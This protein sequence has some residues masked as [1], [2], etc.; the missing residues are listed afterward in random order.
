M[1]NNLIFTNLTHQ[2]IRMPLRIKLGDNQEAITC[3]HALRLLPQK[4]LT[5][6][7]TWKNKEVIVKIFFAPLKAKQHIKREIDGYALIHNTTDVLAPKILKKY[8]I[9]EQN[10]NAEILIIEKITAK[11]NVISTEISPIIDIASKLHKAGILLNDMHANNFIQAENGTYVIDPADISVKQTPL[12]IKNILANIAALA[13]QTHNHNLDYAMSIF[14]KYAK[15]CDINFSPRKRKVFIKIY[16]KLFLKR[17]KSLLKKVLRNSSKYIYEKTSKHL[18]ICD[19]E[20]YTQEMQNLVKHTN[21]AFL[22]KNLIKQ[23]GKCTLAKIKIS[24]Q[25]LIIKRYNLKHAFSILKNQFKFSRAKN[26][27]LN[28]HRLWLYDIPTPKPIAMLEKSTWFFKKETF[29][30]C[31]YIDGDKLSVYAEKQSLDDTLSYIKKIVI[32]LIKLKNLAISHGD[33][34]A[35]NFIIY[36]NDVF[37]IDLDSMKKMPKLW[38]KMKNYFIKD[39]NR[40]MRNWKKNVTITKQ[41]QDIFDTYENQL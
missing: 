11:N 33:T 36:K 32:Y 34:K 28:A 40:F 31:E 4:R 30:I 21:T 29:F 14:D 3:H 19:R 12:N 27:W 8:S 2:N 22:Q 6:C 5:A 17:T 1:T 39:K 7:A 20:Y 35:D 24:N 25:E 41:T 26:S 10:N 16:N 23:G 9:K 13:A 38:Y 15:V 18:L 37:F